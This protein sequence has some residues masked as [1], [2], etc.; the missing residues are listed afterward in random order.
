MIHIR[1]RVVALGLMCILFLTACTAERKGEIQSEELGHT[2]ENITEEK[3]MMD[4]KTP[5]S[6]EGEKIAD[7]L[8]DI[9]DKYELIGLCF[10]KNKM[11][12]LA[13]DEY[14]HVICR[15]MENGKQKENVTEFINSDKTYE[16][17]YVQ[18]GNVIV[19]YRTH[20]LDDTQDIVVF[21]MEL[22]QEHLYKK[23]G[24]VSCIYDGKLYHYIQNDSIHGIYERDDRE[25]D[26]A[27]RDF[28]TGVGI[29]EKNM[30]FVNA[31][32]ISEDG[33][34]MY[35]TGQYS[36]GINKYGKDVW[37]YIDMND[38]SGDKL[39]DGY[40]TMLAG[41]KCIIFT[42]EMDCETGYDASTLEKE[43]YYFQNG[44]SYEIKC[45]RENTESP[46]CVLSNEGNTMITGI[47]ANDRNV[48]SETKSIIRIYETYTNKILYENENYEENNSW[49]RDAVIC[50]K[51]NILFGFKPSFAYEE[52]ES[53]THKYDIL[54]QSY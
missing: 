37:G 38:S 50:E 25:N 17:I 39:Y 33:K 36:P 53:S 48:E 40:K 34:Y 7:V 3:Y 54:W 24:K 6:S 15:D 9:Q 42:D 32:H 30:V 51:Y 43:Y 21:S 47:Y 46:I 20:I 45:L 2:E 10:Y 35:I 11:F 41:D 29:A 8:Y 12:V 44:N 27:I 28:G 4:G 26:T 52:Q 5:C 22:E 16:E 14:I 19:T 49:M 23:V 18:N 31:L 1:I 13:A